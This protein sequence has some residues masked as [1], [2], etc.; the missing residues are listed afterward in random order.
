MTSKERPLVEWVMR[1][2]TSNYYLEL[3]DCGTHLTKSSR[4]T[5]NENALVLKSRRRR[6]AEI[7]RF[8]CT[9]NIFWTF[10]DVTRE[11]I[12]IGLL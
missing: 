8:I 1:Q 6:E 11:I 5:T 7:S 9:Q 10:M 3:E 4:N 12:I 2:T